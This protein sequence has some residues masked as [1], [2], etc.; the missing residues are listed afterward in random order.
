MLVVDEAAA[1]AEPLLERDRRGVRAARAAGH[2]LGERLPA[3]RTAA[4]GRPARSA[5]SGSARRPRGPACRTASGR[6]AAPPRGTRRPAR[7]SGPSRS[8]SRRRAAPASGSARSSRRRSCRRA[9]AA[10]SAIA[11]PVGSYETLPTPPPGA[12]RTGTLPPGSRWSRRA[13]IVTCCSSQPSLPQLARRDE[14]GLAERHR[15]VAE[16]GRDLLEPGPVLDGVQHRDAP[17]VR[18]RPG[19]HAHD[20]RRLAVEGEPAVARV[21]DVG[22][23]DRLRG[24]RVRV[25]VLPVEE[26]ALGERGRARRGERR[27]HDQRA[28]GERGAERRAPGR[29]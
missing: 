25:P 28:R 6:R 26:G 20:G 4:A 2:V 29:A 27:Q 11:T 22:D 3:A 9:R 8:A 12:K 7:R 24:L 1:E 16:L 10:C 19:L 5:S 15:R 18:L 14:P 13:S 17:V 23:V 21:P